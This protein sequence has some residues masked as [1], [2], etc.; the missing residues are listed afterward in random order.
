[1]NL[2][3]TEQR[4]YEALSEL[5]VVDAH[6]HLPP[7]AVRVASRVDVFTLF[8]HYTRTDFIS[9]GLAPQD[10]ERMIDPEEPLAERW[11]LFAPYWERI[12][13]GSYARPALIAVR[14]FYGQEDITE[15]NYEEI[16][17]RMQAANKPGI[18]HRILRE[19]CRIRVA[20]TQCGRTDVDRDLLVPLMPIDYYANVRSAEEIQQRASDLGERVS[21]LED[22][23]TVIEKGVAK[24]KSEGAVGLKMASREYG[25]AD[26]GEAGA[27]FRRLLERGT[28]HL[29]E[30]NPLRAF[31]LHQILDLA[32]REELVVAVHAG[33]WGDFRTLAPGHFIPIAMQH[34]QTRFDLYHMGMPYVR[35]AGVI[36]KNFPNVWLNLCWS[37]IISPKMTCAALDEWMDLVPLNKIIAFGGDY[38][39]PVEKVYGHLLMA[40]EDIAKVLAGRVE[41]GLLSEEQAVKIGRQWFYENPQEL[42][43]L[44]LPA[45]PSPNSNPRYRK[46][47]PGGLPKGGKVRG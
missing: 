30:S 4:L 33:M 3:A 8:S 2:S 22:Y 46:R 40:R 17:A 1:M 42:Y 32:A 14:E 43:R 39:K 38:S 18:Y 5:E 21:S 15:D 9:A 31:L 45:V 20:L 41:E 37:H 10:Y 47:L 12:R 19:K 36:G 44:E 34:P 25:P 27:I 28:D 7:E 23:L 13:F 29:P 16:S 26:R 35:E 24:W 11:Q 6:E